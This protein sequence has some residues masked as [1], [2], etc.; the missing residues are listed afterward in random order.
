MVGVL[1]AVLSLTTVW[2]PVRSQ[3][4]VIQGVVL[5]HASGRPMSR[6]VLRLEPIPTSQEAKGS[7]LN[8]RSGRS[9]QF[10]FPSVSP[11]LYV[12]IATREGY[13]PCAYGQRLTIGRGMPF[14]VTK[15]STMFAELRLK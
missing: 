2:L 9:G 12:L 6:A 13:F 4:G 11:G 8:I 1:L 10:A 7:P 15:D 3:C 5:E 14:Q